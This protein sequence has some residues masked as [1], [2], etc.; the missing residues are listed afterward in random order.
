MPLLGTDAFRNSLAEG[1]T[2]AKQSVDVLSAYITEEGIDWLLSFVESKVRLRVVVRWGCS[3][4]VSGASDVGVYDR[5]RSHGS[6]LYVL[7]DLHAKLILIDRLAL[8]VGSANITSNG[9]RLVPGGN[10]ELCVKSDADDPQIQIVESVINDSTKMTDELYALVVAEL[11]TQIPTNGRVP[12]WSSALQ[13]ALTRAPNSLWVSEMMWSPTP[14]HLLERPGDEL[15]RHDRLVLGF[16]ADDQESL[17]KA[18]EGSRCWQWLVQTLRLS[19][20]NTMYFGE[21]SQRLHSTL[22]DDP[23]PYRQEVKSLVANLLSF[24]DELGDGT[25]LIDRPNHSQRVRLSE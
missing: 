10:R 5:L 18:F 20:D 9:L 25:I 6:E 3:D 2:N 15:S 1:L 4:L 23:T 17:S 22:I 11:A 16:S 19:P 24:A 7:R 8:F 21:L 14:E 12:Q 13:Q